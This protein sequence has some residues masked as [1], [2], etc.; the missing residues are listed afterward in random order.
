M[1]SFPILVSQNPIV[2]AIHSGAAVVILPAVLNMMTQHFP[3]PRPQ[4]PKLS[5]LR[6]L[7]SFPLP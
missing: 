1:N 6:G 5:S 7:Q 2:P 3:R 4:K